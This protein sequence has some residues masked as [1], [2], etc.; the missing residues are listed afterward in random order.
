MMPDRPRLAGAGS[1]PVVSDPVPGRSFSRRWPAEGDFCVACIG[2]GL[3]CLGCLLLSL[4]L[5]RHYRQAFPD[6]PA[7]ERRR[8]PLR[9]AGYACLGL[10]LWPCIRDAGLWV[11]IILWASIAALSAVL[12]ILLLTYRPRGTAAFGC[13]AAGLVAA[14]LLL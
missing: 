11:G 1:V 8:W 5:R 7:Y 9:I 6:S 14:G 13:A 2:L 3:A 12:L 4:S 10:S